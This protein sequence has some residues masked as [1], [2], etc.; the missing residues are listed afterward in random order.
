MLVW[1]SRDTGGRMDR[2]RP[3]LAAAT[4]TLRACRCLAWIIEC[5]FISRMDAGLRRLHTW[6]VGRLSLASA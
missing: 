3:G 4:L 1:L 2:L 6:A 5:T